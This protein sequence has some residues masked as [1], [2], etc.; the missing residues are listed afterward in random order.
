V[1]QEKDAFY[2]LQLLGEISTEDFYSPTKGKEGHYS[3]LLKEVLK[4]PVITSDDGTPITDAIP[5]LGETLAELEQRAE[6]L[7]RDRILQSHRMVHLR[8]AAAELGV[9]ARDGELRRLLADARRRLAGSADAIG[10]RPLSL[11]PVPWMVEGLLM[12]RCMNLL[13]AP[14]KVG[15]TSLAVQMVS[16]WANGAG[17]YLGQRICCP[18]P[19]VLIVGPDMPEGDWGLML[20]D[21]KLLTADLRLTAPIVDLF[22]AGQPITL[23]EE[24]IERIGSYAAS[25]PGLLVILDSVHTATVR[26]GISE[27]DPEIAQPLLS[28]I[29]ALEP[30]GATLLAI[31]HAN[32]ARMGEAPTLAS[33]GSSAIPAL[34]SHM[35]GLSRLNQQQANGPTDRRVVL[36]T[37]GR[38]GMPLEL[39]IERTEDSGWV[40]HGD[41]EAVQSE[42][43]RQ[44]LESKLNDRQLEALE[45]CRDR[46]ELDGLKTDAMDLAGLLG[47]SGSTA[48]RKARRALD[49]LAAHGL[50]E[51]EVQN[52]GVSRRKVF[53]PVGTPRGGV[54][55]RESEL[56]GLSDP[57]TERPGQI[58][59]KPDGERDRT[60]RIDKTLLETRGGVRTLGVRTALGSGADAYGD[61]DDP[62]WG[63]RAEAV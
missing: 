48:E 41:A 61:D 47:M 34:A 59:K 30:H 49:Q 55:L 14:P 24:G 62:A 1:S 54:S 25:H 9:N 44:E 46:W 37:E 53:R 50:L 40:C 12:A 29:E 56:S 2:R 22:T 58:T 51:H 7:L 63:P 33:R 10:H 4:R 15:K 31:H 38:G 13:I 39:L 23:D 32:K 43:H 45:L 17:S 3:S 36:K 6:Q 5:T 27:N 26:L 19:P 20:R 57:E 52:T 11:A 35:V 18:C 42:K 21:Q 60:L 28:L 8:A 16:Q